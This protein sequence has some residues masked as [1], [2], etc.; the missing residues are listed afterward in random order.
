MSQ[1]VTDRAVDTDATFASAEKVDEGSL[2]GLNGKILAAD[3]SG[4]DDR[5]FPERLLK[6][7]VSEYLQDTRK[8]LAAWKAE[9]GESDH[10]TQEELLRWPSPELDDEPALYREK[11]TVPCGTLPEKRWPKKSYQ[12][13]GPEECIFGYC[14][15][16]YT[17]I[18]ENMIDAEVDRHV[19]QRGVPM[20][21]IEKS[22]KRTVEDDWIAQAAAVSG[23]SVLEDFTERFDILKLRCVCPKPFELTYLK[24][25]H[26]W[27]TKS[28]KADQQ[29]GQIASNSLNELMF[30]VY[31]VWVVMM[32]GDD[33]RTSMKYKF[34]FWAYMVVW[35]AKDKI[36]R[37]MDHPGLGY[38]GLEALVNKK[39]TVAYAALDLA[40]RLYLGLDGDEA[41]YTTN[42]IKQQFK[43]QL[44][45]KLD[46]AALKTMRIKL[47]RAIDYKIMMSNPY[48]YI[49][50]CANFSGLDEPK[51]KELIDYA[52]HIC[53]I[54]MAAECNIYET[55][56]ETNVSVGRVVDAQI[57]INPRMKL[58]RTLEHPLK[59]GLAAFNAALFYCG[60]IP[61]RLASHVIVS[62]CVPYQNTDGCCGCGKMADDIYK[63][64]SLMCRHA[65]CLH[66]ALKITEV[67]TDSEDKDVVFC[68]INDPYVRK[69]TLLNKKMHR[70]VPMHYE[71]PGRLTFPKF[72]DL[73]FGRDHGVPIIKRVQHTVHTP[74]YYSDM[75]MFQFLKF[76]KK[77]GPTSISILGDLYDD[78]NSVLITAEAKAPVDAKRVHKRVFM[79]E[80]PEIAELEAPL[81]NFKRRC[82]EAVC[83]S[84]ANARR[85]ISGV[86]PDG[87]TPSP[88]APVSAPATQAEPAS[89]A[90]P[91]LKAEP[92]SWGKFDDW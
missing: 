74:V 53:L 48:D 19:L 44:G 63:V 64:S 59:L 69:K 55:C 54:Y 86:D 35:Q 76:E 25:S 75:D 90:E 87:P 82:V 37:C 47:L 61:E 60:E 31:Q 17:Q 7:T 62:M 73:F 11:D 12:S 43:K 18:R 32:R 28:E 92:A 79:E 36:M 13:P 91:A 51:Q 46:P 10:E 16:R 72:E 56:V 49:K 83:Q 66:M 20:E 85:D 2:V 21:V 89:S 38:I 52:S 4:P 14:S 42:S 15:D 29:L 27:L 8:Q 30:A 81:W 1:N 33:E 50:L 23:M 6:M 22:R 26:E 70:F 68:M 88:P 80:D 84:L 9:E 71:F 3:S 57:V 24:D 58:E 78:V 5:F 77:L 65:Y 40:V 34:Y 45:W 39:Y 41:Q 67:K